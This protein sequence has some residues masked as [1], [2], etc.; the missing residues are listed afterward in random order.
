MNRSAAKADYQDPGAVYWLSSRLQRCLLDVQP[1]RP[2]VIVCIGTDRSTGDSLGPLVGTMLKKRRIEGIAVY[3][4]LDE[5]V[6]AVNLRDTLQ[7]I[8]ERFRCPYIIAVDACLGQLSSIGSIQVGDGPMKPGAG[9][10]KD[11]PPVGDI[12]ITG[13][14][15][16]GGFMEYLVLQNTR[17]SLVM[18]MAERI[19]DGIARSLAWRPKPVAADENALRFE[20]LA[21]PPATMN[22]SIHPY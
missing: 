16:V 19:A 7:A 15:N 4:T 3:G 1:S 9:V 21:S 5:P 12:H 18:N 11:L 2:I 13:I 8:E 10:N 20:P 17:L 22:I 6:H 14:V